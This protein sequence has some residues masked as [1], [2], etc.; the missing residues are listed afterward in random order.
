MVASASSET[1]P[2]S[3]RKFSDRAPCAIIDGRPETDLQF[4][5][6]LSGKEHI[7]HKLATKDLEQRTLSDDT[8]AAIMSLA[9]IQGRIHRRVLQEVLERCQY[10]YY[11]SGKHPSVACETSWDDLMQ[12]AVSLILSLDITT[13]VLERF[14]LKE[15]DLAAMTARPKTWVDLAILQVVGEEDL[16]AGYLPE[17]LDFHRSVSD[18]AAAHLNL[19]GDNTFRTPWLAAKLLSKDKILA[20]DSA[21]ALV[22]HLATTKPGNRTTFE[23]RLISQVELWK[24]LADFSAADLQPFCGTTM[25]GISTCLSSWLLGSCWPQIMSWM[26]RGPMQGGSG[27]ATPR[28]PSC[29]RF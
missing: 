16:V 2:G 26:Q 3:A 12:E 6:L 8:R 9:G 22:R 19:L 25:G 23:E 5:R 10:L 27:A 17:S 20:R 14:H 1:A 11:W 18:Q 15:E 21:S 13:K 24:N 4:L 28:E 29:C 7:L